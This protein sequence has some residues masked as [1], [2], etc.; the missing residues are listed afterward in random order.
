MAEKPGQAPF[1]VQLQEKTRA[2]NEFFGEE[3]ISERA[4]EDA[5]EVVGRLKD[6]G[7]T[8]IAAIPAPNREFPEGVLFPGMKVGLPGWVYNETK[9]RN[10][11]ISRD[12]LRI[13]GGIAIVDT[14]PKPN[15]GE[16]YAD[17]ES[18][19]GLL[20]DLRRQGGIEITGLTDHL[21]ETSRWGISAREHEDT[22]IPALA[23]QIGIKDLINEGRAIARSPKAIESIAYNQFLGLPFGDTTG[24]EWYADQFDRVSR[25]LGGGSDDG[26][27]GIVYSGWSDHHY[28]NIAGRVLV[29][30]PS[31][32]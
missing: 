8:N 2:W 28:V 4:V 32:A 26:G 15:I 6:K 1:E 29:E 27:L 31:Q 25:L 18:Y 5:K 7:W 17:P 11:R 14:T 20:A 9:G 19:Q 24:W 21:P 30:I 22:V 10:P 12:S 23:E 16:E 13:N 3:R